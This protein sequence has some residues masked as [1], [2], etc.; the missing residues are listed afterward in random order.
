MIIKASELMAN[1]YDADIAALLEVCSQ[2]D[3]RVLATPDDLD[4][5][6]MRAVQALVDLSHETMTTLG[7]VETGLADIQRARW[8]QAGTGPYA[9]QRLHLPDPLPEADHETI[10]GVLGWLGWGR[11]K[12]R[13]A[14]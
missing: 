14:P 13:Q 12:R 8:R 4:S 5:D 10:P 1:G 2:L 9:F 11:K 7:A 3:E 6:P